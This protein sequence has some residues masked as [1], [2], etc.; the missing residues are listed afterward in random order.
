MGI[1]SVPVRTPLCVLDTA[2]IDLPTTLLPPS[3]R[4]STARA[5][6]PVRGQAEGEAKRTQ[7]R[8][9]VI[10][11][12]ITYLSPMKRPGEA[13]AEERVEGKPAQ[14]GRSGR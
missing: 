2:R 5:R 3:S 13:S 4:S 12:R 7:L 14:G 11:D 10:E 6:L 1:Q 9:E 8:L